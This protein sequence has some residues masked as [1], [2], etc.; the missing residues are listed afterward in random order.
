M[1]THDE[2]LGRLELGLKRYKHGVR[3]DDD[4]RTWG[5]QKNSWVEMTKEELIDALVVMN[6]LYQQVLLN[7]L[8]KENK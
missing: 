8:T 5:T 2:L 6:S 3:V 1:G 4:T 7:E